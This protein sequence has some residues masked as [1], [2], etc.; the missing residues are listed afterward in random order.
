MT[1]HLVHTLPD[2]YL[3]FRYG[4]LPCTVVS[5][6]VL[7][8]GPARESF[9]NADPAVV[10]E[11]LTRN[12]LPTDTIRLNQNLL[13]VEVDGTLVM[14]DTGVGRDRSLGRKEFGPGTGQAV[15]NLRRAGIEPEDIDL[16][17]LT[18]AHPDHAWGLA[19]EEG[20][21]VYANARVA[22]GQADFHWWTDLTRLR[23][24]MTEH[25][26]DQILG[27]HKNLSAYEGALFLLTGGE[28]LVPGIRA[29][30][31]PGHSPGHMVYEIRSAGRT[32]VCWGDLCH[33]Q[34]LL[35]QRPDWNFVFDHTAAD[36]TAQRIATYSRVDQGRLDVFGYH[37]PFPGLGNLR[38]D[39]AGYTWLPADLPRR[40]AEDGRG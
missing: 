32:M 3:H 12:Y 20:R 29:V 36:A 25:Q 21:P 10:D 15:S 17:A 35:L 38:R 34:V 28:E 5:D 40:P 11:L 16:I 24:D 37:F 1:G 39:S 30:A 8:L 31:T 27:A 23:D 33:H 14:F 18:H 7:V 4:N 19:D 9:P 2:G 26:R 22:V 6:G 13:V